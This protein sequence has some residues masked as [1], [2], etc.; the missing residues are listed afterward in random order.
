MHPF[1]YKFVEI[2]KE[3]MD[4]DTVESNIFFCIWLFFEFINLLTLN[5]YQNRKAKVI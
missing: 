3:E 2:V 5:W 1:P 4:Q